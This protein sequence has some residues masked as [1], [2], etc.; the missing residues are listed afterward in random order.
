MSPAGPTPAGPTPAGP[1]PDG[2]LTQLPRLLALLPYLQA[3]P[4]VRLPDVAATFG[5]TVDRLRKDLDLLWVCGLPGHGPGDLID[6]EW[7]GESITVL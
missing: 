6:L 2:S 5:V 3:H 7:S 1:T 4:G